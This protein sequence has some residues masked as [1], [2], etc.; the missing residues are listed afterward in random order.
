MRT[1]IKKRKE[2]K[3]ENA[4]GALWTPIQTHS[5][6]MDENQ[7]F[8]FLFFFFLE[9]SSISE[10]MHFSVDPVHCS[11]DPQ[12]SFFNKIFIKNRSYDTIHTFKNYF[13][14]IFLI[15]NF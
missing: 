7:L 12:I 3:E 6:D 10:I 2:K 14:T 8:A 11:R 9:K 4:N 13:A 1:S 5:L 15:F